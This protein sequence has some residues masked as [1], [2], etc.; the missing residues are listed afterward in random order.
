ML[1]QE[2]FRKVR[3][4]HVVSF[5][6]DC[7]NYLGRDAVAKLVGQR[8]FAPEIRD[9]NSPFALGPTDPHLRWTNHSFSHVT[10]IGGSGAARY[11]CQ[12]FLLWYNATSFV[13]RSSM[14]CNTD[15]QGAH[16]ASL[17][18]PRRKARFCE[19]LRKIGLRAH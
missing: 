1:Q 11:R 14:M 5:A 3:N 6:T 16:S 9:D 17:I 8:E 4:R 19:V 2:Y 7:V 12:V 13:F 15:A 10:A 18:F